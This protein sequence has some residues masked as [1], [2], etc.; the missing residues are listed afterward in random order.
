MARG[1]WFAE[2]YARRHEA[3]IWDE[4]LRRFHL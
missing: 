4:Y 2:E 1:E 3:R